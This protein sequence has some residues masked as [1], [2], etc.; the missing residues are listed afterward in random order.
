V[1]ERAWL[2]LGSWVE[3]L[4]GFAA[5]FCVSSRVLFA[6]RSPSTSAGHDVRASRIDSPGTLP[7]PRPNPN[8]TAP[9]ASAGP[10]YGFLEVLQVPEGEWLLQTAA[11]ST[12]GRMLIALAKLRGVRT[13]N[14]VR[15]KAQAKDLL[16]NGAG[17]SHAEMHKLRD[18][19]G[20]VTCYTCPEV[21]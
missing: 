4:E 3:C 18:G 12:L 15:R 11:G 8:M 17:C 19:V 7:R 10:A 16:D 2:V 1:H 13:L 14:V 20:T 6:G 21:A 5:S 9:R